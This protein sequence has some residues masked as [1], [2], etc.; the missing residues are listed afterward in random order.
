MKSIQDHKA[1]KNRIAKMMSYEINVGP[2]GNKKQ[3]T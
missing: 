3:N 2:Q 1:I